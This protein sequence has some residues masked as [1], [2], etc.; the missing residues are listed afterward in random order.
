MKGQKH[1]IMAYQ[2]GSCIGFV[3]GCRYS[4]GTFRLVKTKSQAKGYVSESTL[5]SDLDF[6]AT[7][8][9][10]RGVSFCYD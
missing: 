7:A 3:G 1:Y 10:V 2:N 6:L 9:M 8:G 5:Q 4:S